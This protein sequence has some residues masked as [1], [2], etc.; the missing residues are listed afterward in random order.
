MRA[1]TALLLRQAGYQVGR[2][3]RRNCGA[4]RRRMS[5]GTFDVV[6][7]GSAH[8]KPW[9]RLDLT[10]ADRCASRLGMRRL[11]RTTSK[12]PRGQLLQRGPPCSV[13]SFSHLVPGLAQEERGGRP[14]VLLV[15][16]DQHAAL[17]GTGGE[18]D[19]GGSGR[20]RSRAWGRYPPAQSTAGFNRTRSAKGGPAAGS[21]PGF[22]S[23]CGFPRCPIRRRGPGLS[24]L[25]TAQPSQARAS[26]LGGEERLEDSRS[27]SLRGCRGRC[28][29]PPAGRHPGFA[30]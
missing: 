15:V 3:C 25:T 7:T 6:L 16:D 19:L 20:S 22:R 11:V 4:P 13:D 21:E 24:A 1:T 5:L 2:S 14:H 18:G 29:P 10:G 17:G 9:K 26:G 30:A 27:G 23:R 8:A 28:P 12:V